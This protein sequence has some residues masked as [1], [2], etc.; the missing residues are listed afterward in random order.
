MSERGEK[1]SFKAKYFRLRIDRNSFTI[2]LLFIVIYLSWLLA[3]PLFGPINSNFFSGFQALSID[4]GKWMMLFLA[5]MVVSSLAS[6]FLIDKINK[7]IILILVS[8]VAAS[9]ITFSFTWIDYSLVFVFSVL[10]GSAAGI[11]PVA[12]G[13]YFADHTEPEDR[14]RVMG[15]MFGLAM[16]LAQL[17]LFS[18]LS[19]LGL[20]ANMQL[21]I[22][23]S[24]LLITFA[25]LVLKPKENIETARARSRPASKRQI[26]LYGIPMFLFYVVAGILLSIV[27]PTM[28]SQIGADKF[29]LIWAIP[30]LV[31]ALFAGIQIDARGR[32]FPTIVGL[33][34]TG[35][36]LAV[37]GIVGISAGYIT[38]IPL[39]IGYAFVAIAS[40]II[41]ADLAPAKSRGKFYGMGIALIA[42]AQLVGLIL[43]GAH[44]GIASSAQI[45]LYMLFSAVALFL[46]IPP[47]IL[48]EESLPKEVIE[49]RQMLDHLEAVKDLFGKK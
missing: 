24:L 35:I 1:L 34:I 5:S 16:P 48:A 42:G 39:A 20:T 40:L 37:L 41:W 31:G 13:A 47:L 25:S 7:K 2:L 8:A 32:K 28:E 45:N 15:I 46:C 10:L 26:I 29:Y 36:S 21:F 17:F 43:T 14:G 22:A 44:F 6:G 11:S 30:F 38:I 9:L 3:F 27:F 23:G 18:Q 19:G 12:W 49:D 33:A 4:K